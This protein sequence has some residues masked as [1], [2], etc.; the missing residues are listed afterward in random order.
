MWEKSH[1]ENCNMKYAF[2]HSVTFKKITFECVNFQK[3]DFFRTMLK[4][5]DFSSCDI[6]AITV[7]DTFEELRGMKISAE[8]AISIAQILEMEIL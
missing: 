5:I 2:F 6:Q 1:I 7:S 4:D 8:Q 3:A